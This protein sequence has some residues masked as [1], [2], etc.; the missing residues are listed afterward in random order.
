MLQR[1]GTTVR[2]KAQGLF[3]GKA[4]ETCPPGK[5]GENVPGRGPKAGLLGLATGQGGWREVLLRTRAA[6]DRVRGPPR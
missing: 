4:R 5:A 2:Q 3:H 6:G 1:E